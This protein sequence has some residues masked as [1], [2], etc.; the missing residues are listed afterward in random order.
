MAAPA[1]PS[2]QAP[3]ES[4]DVVALRRTERLPTLPGPHP[5][6]PS[7]SHPGRPVPRSLPRPTLPSP[8]HRPVRRHPQHRSDQVAARAAAPSHLTTRYSAAVRRRRSVALLV[9]AGLAALA[10]VLLLGQ[11]AQTARAAGVPEQTV[12]VKVR[13]GESL[14]QI[15]RRTA[16]EAEPGAV[17]ERIVAENGLASADVSPGQVVNVPKG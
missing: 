6:R 7:P 4:A 2:Q 14:W 16:P 9:L 5:S 13:A 1:V 17:V 15:A 8:A 10:V 11:L 3:P 12:Q